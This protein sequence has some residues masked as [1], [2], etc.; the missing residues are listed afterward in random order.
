MDKYRRFGITAETAKPYLVHFHLCTFKMSV[1][2]YSLQNA[3]V[4]FHIGLH[5][6]RPMGHGRSKT[7]RTTHTATLQYNQALRDFMKLDCI[8]ISHIPVVKCS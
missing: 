8:K 2:G 4:A 3:I 6:Y 1:P 5:I 7:S